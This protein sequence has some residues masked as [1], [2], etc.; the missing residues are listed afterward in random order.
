MPKGLIF[1]PPSR[2]N[3]PLFVFVN[4]NNSRSEAAENIRGDR[5]ER[6]FG[7]GRADELVIDTARSLKDVAAAD[8]E[9]RRVQRIHQSV[10]KGESSSI[11]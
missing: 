9:F 3:C 2:Q 11:I 7:P 10:R 6:S 5:S 4:E 8:T 1:S